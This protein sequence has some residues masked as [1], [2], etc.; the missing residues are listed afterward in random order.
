MTT[1]GTRSRHPDAG[2]KEEEETRAAN[3]DDDDVSDD[4][5]TYFRSRPVTPPNDPPSPRWSSSPE[6]MSG[7]GQRRRRPRPRREYDNESFDNNNNGRR[8]QEDWTWNTVS[9]WFQE[10]DEP[11]HQEFE[12][13][14]RPQR[15]KSDWSGFSFLD[16]FLGLDRKDLRRQAREYDERMGI[17]SSPARRARRQRPRDLPRRS[18]GFSYRYTE[19]DE[20]DNFT[21]DDVVIDTESVTEPD[22]TSE[23]KSK[24]DTKEEL[25]WEER[26]MAIERVPPANVT[27]WGVTGDLGIDARTKA[28]SD[29]LEDIAG[30]RQK[31]EE[32]EKKEAKLREDMA[33]MR[34]DAELDKKR[35]RQ[36][37]LE[38]RT[39]Q[40]RIRRLDRRIED[41]ARGLRYAQMK[42]REARDDLSELENRHW[43]VLSFYD[44]GRATSGVEEAL[45]E[46]EATEPAVRRFVEK[47]ASADKVA[48]DVISDNNGVQSNERA[49]PQGEADS[50]QNKE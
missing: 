19:D 45:R 37:Q 35:L 38:V 42:V 28:I 26:A 44:P 40:D 25:T 7:S 10:D 47:S 3:G 46:L 36:S 6:H 27:A 4:R 22:E 32:R 34:I 24:K 48:G 31:V 11:N 33:L 2:A 23:P 39:I 5:S 49:K 20:N 1:T 30:A 12:P 21:D 15:R 17:G 8:Y 29:A 50:P 14:T 16:S 43:A 9:S 41:A 18:N 13:P